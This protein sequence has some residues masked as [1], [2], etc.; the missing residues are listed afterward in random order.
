MKNESISGS[1]FSPFELLAIS[2]TLLVAACSVPGAVT[3][4]GARLPGPIVGPAHPEKPAFPPIESAKWKQGAFPSIEALREMSSGMGKDQVRSLLS[5]PHFSE[6]FADVREWNYIF[7]FRTGDG[8]AYVTCQYMVRFNQE[9]L[10][11]GT[12][13][14]S[15]ECEAMAK[16]SSAKP[17]VKPLAVLPSAPPVPQKV[18]LDADGMFRLDGTSA[19]DLLPE[20]RRKVELLGAEIR[21]NFRALKSVSVTGHTD[22]LG[23]DEHNDALSLARAKTVRDLLVRQGIDPGLIRTAGVGRKQPVT[24]CAGQQKTPAL[25]GCLRPNRRVEVEVTGDQ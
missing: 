23:S 20:G 24:Q 3:D 22:H 17:V 21:R 14:N 6:G 18:T 16:R 1:Q 25:V 19:A 12:Y 9:M 11:T 15:P 10:S 2:M 13:W 7:H 5:H 4:P 8:P